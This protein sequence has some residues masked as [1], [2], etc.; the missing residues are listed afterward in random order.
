M[1]SLLV[2]CENLEGGGERL[3][4][5]GWSCIDVRTEVVAHWQEHRTWL[6]PPVFLDGTLVGSENPYRL[7]EG[8]TRVAILKGLLE[9]GLIEPDSTHRIWYGQG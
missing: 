2:L 9:H 3:R 6:S 8:H 1:D 7:V 4:E 5:K